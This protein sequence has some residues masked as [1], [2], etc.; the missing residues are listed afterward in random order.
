MAPKKDSLTDP[1]KLLIHQFRNYVHLINMELDLA[2]R[3]REKSK[4]AEL[5]TAVDYM[6]CSL[7]DL[8]VRLVRIR[9]G[10]RDKNP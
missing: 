5:V 10:C 6:T 7:E 4:Y 9:E 2:E 1:S 3:G 8:R